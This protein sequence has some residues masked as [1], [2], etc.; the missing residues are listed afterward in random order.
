[1]YKCMEFFLSRLTTFRIK[2]S[3]WTPISEQKDSNLS[4]QKLA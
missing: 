3:F 4:G 1:M 2:L